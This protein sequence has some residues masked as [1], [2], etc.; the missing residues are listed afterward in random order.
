M[1][2]SG[3]GDGCQQLRLFQ[4]DGARTAL[5]GLP[6]HGQLLGLQGDEQLLH[7]DQV[8]AQQRAQGQHALAI[9]RQQ[10]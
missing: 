4:R 10:A 9:G 5:H 3:R 2:C 7:S 6:Q 8:A 1:S